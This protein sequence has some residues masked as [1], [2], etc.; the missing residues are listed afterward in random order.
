MFK[1]HVQNIIISSMDSVNANIAMSM[2]Y[3][4]TTN[5]DESI[6]EDFETI[7]VS[8]L[9]SVSGTHITSFM[10]II[11][12]IFGIKKKRGKSKKNNNKSIVKHVIQIICIIIYIA[13]VGVSASV[14]R[15]G[16]MLIISIIYSMLDKR[17]NTYNILGITLLIILFMNPYSIFNTGTRLSFLATT[18]II[19]FRTH[20]VNLFQR[21]TNKIK[22]EKIQKITEYII[23]SISI[24]IAVQMLIIPIQI[25]A[26]NRLPFPVIIP[27]LILG[28]ISGPITLIGMIGIML[29]FIPTVS[30]RLFYL[31]EMFVKVLVYLARIFKGMSFN[32]STVS[33][34]LIFFVLYYMLIIVIYICFKLKMEQN[35]NGKYNMKR[36]IKY[37]RVF[38]ITLFVITI[39]LVIAFNIYSTYLSEYVYFFNVEQGDMS[40]IKSG[41]A[42]IIVDIGSM[43][44]NLSF[45]VISNHFKTSNL[46]KVDAVIISHMHKDHVNGLEMF[47]QNYEVGMVIYAKPKENSESF[48]NFKQLLNKY[49]IQSKEVKQGD[50]ISIGK[51]EIQVLLPDDKYIVSIDEVNA[52]SLVCKITVN[53]KCLLYMGDASSET[54]EKLI[55]QNT[56]V[57]KIYILKV[58]HHG[59]K[60]ATSKDFIQ[61]IQPKHAIISALKKYYGHPH[62][63]TLLTLK[64]NNV[65]T[66]LTEAGAIK[67][68]LN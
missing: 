28:I 55:E 53:N 9:M 5:L 63:N 41:N 27:N 68:S 37:L 62:E 14:M 44:N 22:N 15:A 38:A 49:N 56:D 21:I 25:Q 17:K 11:N 23:Q 66:Y 12:T 42:S 46:N 51:I 24:T 6:Q 7:G 36:L 39:T 3:G 32:I 64:E 29:S 26:F 43:S 65:C 33:Q 58:G 20:I 1:Q 61:K 13:F 45:N 8:H 35:K 31:V 52:N 50:K 47:I 67:F 54:E 19:L 60:T 16:I 59:S 18:G 34:P 2:I 40:Y 4:D 30:S 10:I 48:Q 57:K